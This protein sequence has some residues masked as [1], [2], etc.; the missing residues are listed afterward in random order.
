MKYVS[1][2]GLEIHSQLSVNTKIFCGCSVKFGAEQNTQTCPVCSGF[3]GTLP[4]L[5]K[6]AVEYGVKAGLA[7]KCSIPHYNKFDRKNYFYPDLPKAYQI[8]Q[9]DKPL[10]LK[11]KIEI[12]VNGE[13]KTIGITRIHLEEDAG[14]LVHSGDFSSANNSFADYNRCG[15]PLIEIVSEPDMRSSDDA[16]AYLQAVKHILEYIEVSDCN[17][18]EGSLRCDAN[19]SVMPEGSKVFGV[20]T[21]LKNMNSF[22]AVKNAVDSEIKRQINE[23]ETG[24]RIIQ[25]TRLWDETAGIT[26]PMRS[27][28][29][30]Q[31]YK[32]FPEP[33]LVSVELDENFI[34]SIRKQLPEL[35]QCRLSRFI[36]EYGLTES[37]AEVLIAQKNIADYFENSV[38]T[39]NLPKKI[40]NWIM[41]DFMFLLK[42]N[43]LE[44]NKSKVMPE[45]IAE[46]ADLIEKNVINGKIAKQ[47]FPEM[48]DSGKKASDIIR[49]KNLVQITDVSEIEKIVEQVI[50]ENPEVFEQIKSGKDKAKGFI[51]GQVMKLSKGKANPALVNEILA[52]K[53][54]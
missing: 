48:F 46:L 10:C 9:Y 38:K 37:E 27:K 40:A 4:V 19:V 43:K 35:P 45:H 30:A 51:V 54:G 7:L 33:D 15:T 44:I 32:Y 36:S 18:E 47:I 14:K 1:V 28:E 53:S 25:E 52:R 12:K 8:S 5:N 24:G 20:K 6:K 42:E 26:R 23:L 3:P 31:D 29:E 39:V 41:G 21:E 2:I 22:K 34:D 17:M 49:D 16:Y 50:T 13:I 11:G